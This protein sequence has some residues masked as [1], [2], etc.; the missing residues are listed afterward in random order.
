MTKLNSLRHIGIVT[1]KIDES[2]SFYTDLGF[3]VYWDKNET[4][5][6]INTILGE[7][8]DYLRTVKM[9]NNCFGIELLDF[10]NE[11]SIGPEDFKITSQLV[12]HIAVNVDN[13]QQIFS[14]YSSL[15][16]SKPQLTSNKKSWVAFMKD[17]NNNMFLE[18]VQ[19]L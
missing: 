18:I 12:T 1:S 11:S 8:I 10:K 14:K 7:K 15:F 6:F 4:G 17:P 5:E 3:E 9:K 16:K 13:I 19:N 2:I